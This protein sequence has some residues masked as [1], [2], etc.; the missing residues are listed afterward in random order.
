MEED[1]TARE[2]SVVE[3]G[4]RDVVESTEAEIAESE[5]GKIKK[6]QRH[7]SL[8]GEDAAGLGPLDGRDGRVSF[9]RAG[10]G[11]QGLGINGFGVHGLGVDSL[12]VDS[13]GVDG[14]CVDVP[15]VGVPVLDGA[16]VLLDARR[17]GVL[18]ARRRLRVLKTVGR[19]IAQV[20][21]AGP[22]GH[23]RESG[24]AHVPGRYGLGDGDSLDGLSPIK[25]KKKER[26]SKW[27]CQGEIWSH[28]AELVITTEW[29]GVC[30]NGAGG[31]EDVQ[32]AD[33]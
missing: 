15:S 27:R 17:L 32:E 5:N 4:G 30:G 1:E 12:G 24:R 18:D 8:G 22:C 25:K 28:L 26:M 19:T 13:L 6:R 31:I 33:D 9:D 10:L 14:L 3:T 29:T 7:T 20:D 21:V 16:G 11:V 2:R 23:H